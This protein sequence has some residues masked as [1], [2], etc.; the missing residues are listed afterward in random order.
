MGF[1]FGLAGMSFG[2]MA[3]EKIAALKK[4]FEKLKKDLAESGVI[5]TQPGTGDK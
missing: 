4:E 3:W 2:I 5:K 1:I